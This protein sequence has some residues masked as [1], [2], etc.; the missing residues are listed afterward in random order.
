[1]DDMDFTKPQPPAEAVPAAAAIATPFKAASSPFY[2]AAMAGKLFRSSGRAETFAAGQAL[3]LED[4][5]AGGGLF[6]RRTASRMYYIAEGEVTLTVAGRPLDTLK[7]GEVVGEMAVITGEPR[8]ATATARGAC[9]AWSMGAEDLQAALAKEPEFAMMVMSVMFDRLRFASARLAAR[10]APFV[11]RTGAAPT[12]DAAQVASLAAA[13]PRSALVR[14]AAG[15]TIMREGQT[16]ACMYAVKSGQVAIGVRE[17]LLEV[18]GAGGT[19]GEMALVDQ[20]PRSASALAQAESEL[21]AIDRGA[22]L[23]AVAGHPAFALALMRSIAGRLKHITA[24]L[25]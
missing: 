8:T 14:Y 25:S 6:S 20:S 11:A 3:F 7:A 19:F 16:G 10:R 17:Q 4:E 18:V 22:F 24:Q 2:N 13:L 1:M 9:A 21:L 5:K 15:A 12:F 23:K